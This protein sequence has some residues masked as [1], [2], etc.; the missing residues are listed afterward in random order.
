VPSIGDLGR[1]RQ[2]LGDRQPVTAAAIASDD[3]YLLLPLK[4]C[5]GSRRL[6]VWQQS[7]GLAPF[8]I[9]DDRPIALVASPRPV[10]D[11]DHRRRDSAWRAATSDRSEQG[12]IAHW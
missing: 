1:L 6:A 3:R 4:P 10:V 9:A 12:V 2:Y 11:P 8:E 5:F 7:D